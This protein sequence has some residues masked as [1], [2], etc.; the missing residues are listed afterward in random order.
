MDESQYR[1]TA[2]F[3]SAHKLDMFIIRNI[4]YRQD[5]PGIAGYREHNMLIENDIGF[6]PGSDKRAIHIEGIDIPAAGM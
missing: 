4:L 1:Q 5:Q 2:Q 6:D 3:G